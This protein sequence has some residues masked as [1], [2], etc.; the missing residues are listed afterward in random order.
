MEAVDAPEEAAPVDESNP[1][2]DPA[3]EEDDDNIP[4]PEE[5]AASISSEKQASS[6]KEQNQEEDVEPQPVDEEME[7]VAAESGDG[8]LEEEP[9]PA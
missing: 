2:E 8:N 1:V 4:P 3:A 7:D 9:N 5:V 6:H